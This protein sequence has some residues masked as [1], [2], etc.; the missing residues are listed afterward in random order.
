MSGDIN[1]FKIRIGGIGH[2][3]RGERFINEVLRAAGKARS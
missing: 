3:G 1:E 2:R